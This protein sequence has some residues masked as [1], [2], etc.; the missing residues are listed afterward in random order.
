YGIFSSYSLPFISYG[1]SA[2]FI[3]SILIG[4]MLSIFRTGEIFRDRS[5]ATIEKRVDQ[6]HSLF[7]YDN[8]KIIINLKRNLY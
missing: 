5:V 3:N 6:N 2:F 8:G 4:F 7:S 1:K